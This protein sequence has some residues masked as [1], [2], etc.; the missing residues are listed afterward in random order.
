MTVNILT[1]SY[2]FGLRQDIS[3][4][5]LVNNMSGSA[6]YFELF[7]YLAVKVFEISTRNGIK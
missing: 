1:I 3:K 2:F 4:R 5:V 6:W 7:L